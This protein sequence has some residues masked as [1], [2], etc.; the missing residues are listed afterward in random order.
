MFVATTGCVPHTNWGCTTD[1]DCCSETDQCAFY[2][3]PLPYKDG[4]VY[5]LNFKRGYKCE[6]NSHNAAHKSSV[7]GVLCSG[8]T[9]AS[10]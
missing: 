3:L 4:D 8:A 7:L 1:S 6:R 9:N 2:Q 5:K 10:R